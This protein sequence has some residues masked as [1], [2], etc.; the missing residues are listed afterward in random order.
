VAEIT[1]F[2]I[3][4]TFWMNLVFVWVAGW[5]AWMN[6]AYLKNHT[7]KMMKMEGGGKIKN[8]VVKIFILINVI[9]FGLFVFGAALQ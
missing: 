6:R 8:I 9:G 1:R 5:L 3:D 7:M 4:Y 2:K